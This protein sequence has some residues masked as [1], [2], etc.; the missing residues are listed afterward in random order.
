MSES[1]SRSRAAIAGWAAAGVFL[2]AGAVAAIYA[3]NLRI[4]LNDVEL[5][6][7]DAVTKMQTL[8]EQVI[9]AAG[10]SD[11]MRASLSL[12]SAP[13]VRDVRLVGQALAPEGT[14]RLFVSPGKGL[15]IAAQ[16]LPPTLPGRTYQLWWQ[17]G[18]TTTS[19][20]IFGAGADGAATAAFDLPPDAG[21]FTGFV[22]TDEAEDGA[23]FP[24][25]AMVLASR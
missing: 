24:S 12:L 1:P 13:D 5:R 22:V 4:Q 21:A 23:E 2:V 20:G 10:Q 7:V 6:L 18:K 16:K 8:Q 19:V 17:N 14:A 3:S 11:G 9:A 15:L 25:S